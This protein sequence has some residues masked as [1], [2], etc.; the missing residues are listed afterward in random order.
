MDSQKVE[1]GFQ[2]H[3]HLHIIEQIQHVSGYKFA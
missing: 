2:K 1:E 3:G